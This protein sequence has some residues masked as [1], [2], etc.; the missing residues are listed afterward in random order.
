[1]KFAEEYIDIP[2]DDKAVIKHARK[3]LLFNESETWMKKDTGLFDVAMGAFDGAK[4][5]ELVGNFLLHKLSEKYERKNLA[6][7][8]DD[9][10]A[11]F[12]NVS[13]PASEKIKIYF[14]ELIREHE[15]ELTIQCNRK[16][17]NFLNATLNLENSLY[18]LTQKTTIT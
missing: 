13:G 6:L 10:L 5:C 12:K 3:S 4:V 11:I 1:M 18:V 15:L 16:V 17:A 14:C 9:G 7:H 8:G 2:T